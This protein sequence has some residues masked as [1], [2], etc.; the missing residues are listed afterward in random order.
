MFKDLF[1]ATEDARPPA[2][3]GGRGRRRRRQD[4]ARLG[5]REVRR[6]AVGP[7]RLAPWP[8]PGLRRGSGVLRAGRGD[9]GQASLGRP[10]R[11]TTDAASGGARPTI[12]E[13]GLE[14]FV[15]DEKERDWLRPR[16]GSLLGI[17]SVGS[18]PREDLFSAW[19][20]FLERA[21]AGNPVVLVIDDAQNADEGLLQFVE[22]LLAVAGVRLLRRAAHPA[23]AARGAAR[24]GREPSRHRRTPGGACRRPRW[25]SC[26]AGWWPGCPTQVRDRLVDRAEGVPLYAV[27]TV[28]S[29]IDRDLVVPR[30]GQYV[31]A[32]GRDLDLDTLPGAC[33]AAGAG[34]RPARRPDPGAATR[35]RPRERGGGVVLAGRRRSRSAPTWRTSPEVLDSLLRQQILSQETRRFSAGLGR[36]SFVQSVVRQVAYSRLSRRDRKAL[37]LAVAAQM[38]SGRGPGRHGGRRRAALPRCRRRGADGPR[39]RR[40]QERRREP[41]RAGRGACRGARRARRGGGTPH[42]RAVAGGSAGEGRGAGGQ[43]RRVPVPGR[44]LRRVRASTRSGPSRCWP[45]RAT[46]WGRPAPP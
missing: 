18:F 26:S 42:G 27:E 24:P 39:R 40:A 21:G 43:P 25:G 30:G 44:P 46:A 8:M 35:R 32:P 37:H 22:H 38:E 33:L 6:R 11:V 12:L 13:Q 41:P 3:A 5:V 10:A 36:Y 14:R 9:P 29:L 15:P 16:L 2:A 19:A 45:T 1:H 7:G 28:R 17:G 4:A 31:L 20:T 34:G 23:R